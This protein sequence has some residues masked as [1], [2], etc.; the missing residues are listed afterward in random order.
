MSSQNRIAIFGGTFNP[1][2]KGHIN[3]CLECAKNFHFDKI[4]LIPTNIPP[5]KQLKQLASNKERFDMCSLA[6]K[7]YPIFEVSDIE[8][9]MQGI[10][11]TVN[12]VNKL[13]ELYPNVELFLIIGSDMLFTFHEWHRYGEILDKVHLIVGAREP[14]EYEKMVHYMKDRLG[15]HMNVH[16]I[17]IH[18]F[19]VS[20][21]QIRT[22][23]GQQGD[24][25][26][27]LQSDVYAYIKANHMY[28]WEG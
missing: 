1:I 22:L 15:G 20:S 12:T 14:L 25:S 13:S 9:R 3:L 26:D 28:E 23:I 2:H 21:T 6:I 18:V 8:M 27:Y 4:L 10:S 5:H 24:V 7:D 19:P 11:Y 17:H 16:V